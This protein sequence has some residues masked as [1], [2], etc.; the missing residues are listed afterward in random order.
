MAYFRNCSVIIVLLIM[1]QLH[2]RVTLT[3]IRITES[4]KTTAWEANG[5]YRG[6]FFNAMIRFTKKKKQIHSD[7][8]L[9]FTDEHYASSMQ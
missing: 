6:S 1:A 9:H 4:N 7:T 3:I 5:H 8:F 2:I